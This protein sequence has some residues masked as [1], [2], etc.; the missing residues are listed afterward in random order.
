MKR[1]AIIYT[2]QIRTN[3]LSPTPRDTKV[4]DSLVKHFLIPIQDKYDYDVFISTDVIDVERAKAFFG[5]HLKNLAIESSQTIRPV[6]REPIPLINTLYGKFV[7]RNFEGL[8]PYEEQYFQYYRAYRAYEMV[9]SYQ[10]ETGVQYDYFIKLRPDIIIQKSLLPIF[11]QL[12][13]GKKVFMEHNLFEV[14]SFE[15]FDVFYNL[16]YHYG[17][18]HRSRGDGWNNHGEYPNFCPMDCNVIKFSSEMQVTNCFYDML[19]EKGYSPSEHFFGSIYNG[20]NGSAHTYC[21]FHR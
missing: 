21:V 6:R 2:G 10:E 3:S 13:S 17:S 9:K 11:E 8:N 14:A 7:Q 19:E 1:I 18:Y 4:L 5:N 16:A 12:D 20:P 15:F